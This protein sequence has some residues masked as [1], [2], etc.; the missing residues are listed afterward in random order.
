MIRHFANAL[1]TA[2][3]T[4][5]ET[6]PPSLETRRKRLRFR[7]WHRGTK[8]VDLLLGRFADKHLANLDGDRLAELERL[9]D[10]PDQEIHAWLT[11]TRPVPAEH[12]TP[13]MRL[14]M[15]YSAKT[16]G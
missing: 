10:V 8:E 2:I 15:D 9:V 13:L 11:G 12:D 1:Q 7:C 16:I 14:L 4:A 6:A 3:S 5:M